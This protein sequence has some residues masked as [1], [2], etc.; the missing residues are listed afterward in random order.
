MQLVTVPPKEKNPGMHWTHVPLLSLLPAGQL[1]TCASAL[2]KPI[3]AITAQQMRNA[4]QLTTH[5]QWRNEM[6]GVFSWIQH[7][8]KPRRR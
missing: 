8:Q 4:R 3:G 6:D 7:N 5:P 1:V 2:E